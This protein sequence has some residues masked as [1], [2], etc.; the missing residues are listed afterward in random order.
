MSKLLVRWVS[1]SLVVVGVPSVNWDAAGEHTYKMYLTHNLRRAPYDKLMIQ[2]LQNDHS[3]TAFLIHYWNEVQFPPFFNFHLDNRVQT[4]CFNVSHLTGYIHF[5]KNYTISVIDLLKSDYL[6]GGLYLFICLFVW[7]RN[8]LFILWDFLHCPYHKVLLNLQN[9]CFHGRACC[10]PLTVWF[11]FVV[12]KYSNFHLFYIVCLLLSLCIVP[13]CSICIREVN[14][15]PW[16]K[17]LHANA[18]GV[19][20]IDQGKTF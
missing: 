17:K 6:G 18:K 4:Y 19:W 5:L 3:K 20:R 7:I 11:E 13:A 14:S 15:W 16:Q 12:F 1:W 2:T 9:S 8:G 10:P